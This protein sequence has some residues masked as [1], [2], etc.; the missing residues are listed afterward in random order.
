MLSSEK[1][2]DLFEKKNHE[3]L[4]LYGANFMLQAMGV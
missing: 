2:S 4:S 1:G 3:S